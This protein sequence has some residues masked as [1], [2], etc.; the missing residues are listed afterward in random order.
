MNA[1]SERS[2]GTLVSRADLLWGMVDGDPGV[3]QWIAAQLGLT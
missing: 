2:H 3:L 1:A